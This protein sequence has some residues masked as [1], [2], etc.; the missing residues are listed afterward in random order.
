MAYLL[1]SCK[2]LYFTLLKEN[3]TNMFTGELV[4]WYVFRNILQK[5]QMLVILII[6]IRKLTSETHE[7]ILWITREDLESLQHVRQS[8]LWQ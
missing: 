4:F 5:E 1:K 2:K 8:F 3:I 6:F 7:I